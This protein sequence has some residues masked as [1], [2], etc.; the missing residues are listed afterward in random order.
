MYIDKITL[1]NIRG[2]KHLDFS[3]A[4]PDGSYAGWTVFTGDNGG[5]KSTLLKASVM[6]LVGLGVAGQLSSSLFKSWMRHETKHGDISL[7]TVKAEEDIPSRENIAF[8]PD[9]KNCFLGFTPLGVFGNQAIPEKKLLGYFVCAYGPYR[10][11]FGSSAEMSRLMADKTTAPFVTLFQESASLAEVDQWMRLLS[12]KKLE[13][14]KAEE[15]QLDILLGI[16]GDDLLPNGITIDRV[17]SDGLWLKDKNGLQLSWGDMS[18]GYR[19]AL[20][21]LADILRHMIEAYGVEDLTGVDADGKLFIKRSGVVL[22]DEIDAHL[23]PSWQ[24]DIGFWLKKHFPAIQFLVTTHS[25]IICQAA[26]PN[27]IFVLPS[28][29]SDDEPRAMTEAEYNEI[30]ASKSDAILLTPAFGLVNTRSNL[31]V[32]NRSE[33]SRLRIKERAGAALTEA[34]KARFEALTNFV[35][36]DAAS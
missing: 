23:H 14:K 17:D 16:L 31:A 22:I 15:K 32:T 25:P 13:G 21:L 4:R 19:S 6:A 11:V 27:G 36:A 29:A 1:T 34:E 12:H 10:R 35:N 18:D 2:F 8:D 26:D 5:G 7:V 24:R 20:A 28:P 30:V 9:L 33:W 3:L